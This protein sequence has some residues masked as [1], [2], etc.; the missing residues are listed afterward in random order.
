VS[1]QLKFYHVHDYQIVSTLVQIA[2]GKLISKNQEVW[3]K[4]NIEAIDEFLAENYVDHSLP[5]EFEGR[6]G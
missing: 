1:N 5:P 3:N 6:R 4:Q 2:Y